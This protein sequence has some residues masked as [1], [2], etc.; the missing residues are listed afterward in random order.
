MSLSYQAKTTMLLAALAG[1]LCAAVPAQHDGLRAKDEGRSRR[2]TV[3]SITIP[4]AVGVPL[5]ERGSE[6]LRPL[7]LT[8]LEDGERQEILSTRSQAEHAPLYLSVFVQDDLVSPAGNE[9]A[10]LADFIRHLPEGTNVMIGYL[11]VGSVQIRQKFTT[12]LERAAKALRIPGG[13]PAVGPYNPY[14]TIIEGI[15][16]YQSQPV[17][18]R[19]V[20]AVTDGLDIS[21][22][23]D[24]SVASQSTDLQR[25]INEA[26]RHGVAVYSIYT[27][28]ANTEHNPTLVNNAQGALARLSDETGGKAF[29][30]GTNAPLSFTPYLRELS[31]T[32]D[33]QIALTYLSTHESKGFHKI[34]LETTLEGAQLVYPTGYKR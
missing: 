4:V 1:S 24:N 19:A 20:L 8:L 7:G 29:F 2:G 34:K 26:Q 15:K 30:H 5:P 27:P 14:S 17:G 25:A 6:E 3:R 11:R 33:K 31:T 13:T 21:R 12:D 16:R 18:R 28:T 22:G 32:L 9:I 10:T 23:V